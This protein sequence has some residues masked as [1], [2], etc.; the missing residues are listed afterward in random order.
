MTPQFRVYYHDREPY[1]GAPELA[2]VFGVLVIVERDPE[3]GRRIIQNGDYYGWTGDR[4]MPFD[5]PGL[6][7]YLQAPGWKRVLI[8]RLVPN[9]DFQRVYNQANTDPDFPIRTAWGRERSK[10]R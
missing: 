8:G 3:H 4:W 1:S 2:P 9:E 5:F 10:I 7:D 6:L